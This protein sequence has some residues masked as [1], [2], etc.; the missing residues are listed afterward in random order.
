MKNSLLFTF[1]VVTVLMQSCFS[2]VQLQESGKRG[3][4]VVESKTFSINDFHSIQVGGSWDIHYEQKPDETPFLR[5]ETDE[6]LF[7]VVEIVIEQGC[8]YIRVNE[9]V[10]PTQ[11]KIYT[12]SR[13]LQSVLVRGSSSFVANGYLNAQN[14]SID[15]TGSGSFIAK[16]IDVE[17]VKV[18]LS[19]SGNVKLGGR[20]TNFAGSISGSGTIFSF[21]LV[22]DNAM[23]KVAGSGN[24]EINAVQSLN[25]SIAGSGNVKYLGKPRV[26]KTIAGSGSLKK[27]D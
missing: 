4:G 24:I 22:A 16:D 12:N 5:I 25:V 20:A 14:L 6:N 27:V 18:S 7:D 9:S 2:I 13:S 1:L 21:G 26:E 11:L 15:V 10:N 3:N 19:G 8:L 17:N 23:L